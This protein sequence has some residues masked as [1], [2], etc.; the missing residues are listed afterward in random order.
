M[1]SGNA[2]LGCKVELQSRIQRVSDFFWVELNLLRQKPSEE[3]QQ[4]NK[5]TKTNFNHSTCQWYIVGILSFRS[6]ISS[7]SPFHNMSLIKLSGPLFHSNPLISLVPTTNWLMYLDYLRCAPER[8]LKASVWTALFLVLA[9][10]P[11]HSALFAL[12][13]LAPKN[14]L[15]GPF[16]RHIL[17][18]LILYKT[19]SIRRLC[20]FNRLGFLEV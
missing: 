3:N 9:L 6:S 16:N 7:Q 14:E 5:S 2:K 8:E 1:R 17:F 4:L 19:L 13:H 12:A 11:Q 15:I 20:F 18:L 10:E